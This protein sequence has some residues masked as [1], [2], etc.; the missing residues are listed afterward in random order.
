MAALRI[1]GAAAPGKVTPE[2]DDA[3]G[4]GARQGGLAQEVSP[5]CAA[6]LI[7]TAT[8]RATLIGIEVHRIDGGAWLLRHARGA[9]IGSV[10]GF[11]ALAA[12]VAG[13]EAAQR[14]V[15]ELVMNLRGAR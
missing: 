12:A 7:V 2:S 5:D 9:V 10:H 1:D 6:K 13:F 3:P 4:Q 14:D 8:A 15:A 11:D